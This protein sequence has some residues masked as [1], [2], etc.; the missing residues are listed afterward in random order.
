[1]EMS[2]IICMI[3]LYKIDILRNLAETCNSGLRKLKL[4]GNEEKVSA[5]LKQ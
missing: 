4:N 3:L 2:L 5:L 1:M